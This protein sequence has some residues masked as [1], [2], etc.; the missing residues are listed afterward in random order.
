MTTQ[1]QTRPD[2]TGETD[3]FAAHTPMM[4]Q[5]LRIKQEYPD[6][7]L[8]YRMGDFYELF[9]EDARHAA[10]LLDLTLT[11]R[12]TSAGEPIPMAGV[13][14]HAYESYLARLLKAGESVAIC[15]QVG[16][17]QAKGP[18]KREVVKVV[19]PGTVTDEA[20]LE[21]RQAHRLVAVHRQRKRGRERLGLAHLD[22]SSGRFAIMAPAGPDELATELA[23]VDP[24]ELLL[25]EGLNLETLTD[26]LFADRG[27]SRQRPVWHF[28]A[29]TA[30][31]QL[32]AQFGT[33]DLAG[34]GVHA[35]NREALDAALGAAGALWQYVNDTQKTRIGH[36]N[37]L[38]VEQTNDALLLDVHTRR[39]LELF[40]DSQGRP[41]GALIG[42]L[43][44]TATGMGARRLREWL[45]RPLREHGRLAAR[46]QAITELRERDL[47]A[48]LFEALRQV[49]DIERI[50]TRIVLGTARPRDLAA[51]RDSLHQ[52]PELTAT[53]SAC[54]QPLL[55]GLVE[56]LADLPEVR[57]LLDAA[58]AEKPSVWLRDG[59]VIASGFDEELDRL[60]GLSE[61]AD[62][63]LT[64]ME[65]DARRQSGIENLKLAYNRVHGYY[66]EVPRSQSARMP[67]TFTRR[68]TLKSVERYT[69]ETLKTFEQE[70]LTAR[71]KALARER[72]C[73]NDLLHR[74]T[75]CQAELRRRAD[76]L[77][78][79]DTLAAL[80]DVAE[81]QQWTAPRFWD[82]VGIEIVQ[83]RHPVV[84]ANSDAVFVPN[85]AGL[86]PD[87]RMLL[88]TGPN[89]G[90][91]S[92]Y[93]RQTALI[94][95]LAHAG[96]HVPAQSATIGPIDRIFTRIGASDDLASGRSTFMVEMTETAEILHH[97]TDRSLV[98]IDEIG[99]GTSTFDGLALAWAVAEHLL[100]KNR[101]MTLFATHYFELTTLA[102]QF[103][104]LVNVHL[105]AITH[106]GELV[107]LH[108][109]KDGPA[110]QSY[111]IDVAK[112]AGL[113]RPTIRR[114]R[115]LLEKLEWQSH[116]GTEA[117]QLDLF[118]AEPVAETV[119][120]EPD[121]LLE[122][123]D[124]L[125]PDG[126]TPKAALDLLYDWKARREQDL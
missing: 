60:R 94:V 6:V 68:Q 1:P 99:R 113:P 10:R 41:E 37:G 124:E 39:H 30:V 101:A 98:L 88:I 33:R 35:D 9:F 95:L 106:Q 40:E 121:P 78:D 51:L 28:A 54:Q 74:L 55:T 71:D 4:Q 20:L 44:R 53:L 84:E 47:P 118:A 76:A 43:D 45:A 86:G 63:T 67:E 77:A 49:N 23:R 103:E 27:L 15:E 112:L 115:G 56:N 57:E 116:A 102:E 109:V 18:M 90:G 70:V 64:A 125:D 120:P 17:V 32:C 97:A 22:L 29:D 36:I 25:A 89:M 24:R 80:S 62:T 87:R 31:E 2:R 123:L 7:L 50:T 3:A 108:G 73:F 122:A 100:N 117:P 81:R 19:T 13:P 34:F 59:G 65:E 114:A 38:S 79:L 52:L 61:R 92:T 72:E 96:A 105:E 11:Q 91:K 126:L 107:F 58:I 21:Q 82:E 66:F 93:M 42:L 14:V 69:N 46:H 111:G 75:T 119:E 110:N 83:G 48:P 8:F 104:T 16:D 5:F 12:G 85:D 26:S